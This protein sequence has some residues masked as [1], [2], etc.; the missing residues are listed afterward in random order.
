MTCQRRHRLWAYCEELWQ[1]SGTAIEKFI[2]SN[3]IMMRLT[4]VIDGPAGAKQVNSRITSEVRGVM[5]DLRRVAI[6]TQSPAQA[7]ISR[8]RPN[9]LSLLKV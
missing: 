6:D 3:L 8:N 5:M 9:D 2:V 1:L 4:A 7:L